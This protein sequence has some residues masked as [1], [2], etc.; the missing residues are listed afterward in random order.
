M[1]GIEDKAI[2][3]SVLDCLLLST[4]FETEEDA[5]NND[6]DLVRYEFFEILVRI[7]HAKYV[8]TGELASD[9]CTRA[10]HRLVTDHILNVVGRSKLP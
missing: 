5:F 9:C 6:H 7:A 8:K 10:L 1:A 2:T 4:N 3:K